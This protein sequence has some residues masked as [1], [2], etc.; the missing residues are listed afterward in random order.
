MSSPTVVNDIVREYVAT[1]NITFTGVMPLH[2]DAIAACV[3][4]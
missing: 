3:L 4:N 2:G 1:R